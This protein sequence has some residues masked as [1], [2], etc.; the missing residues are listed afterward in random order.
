MNFFAKLLLGTKEP[1]YT[2]RRHA[3][4]IYK[5]NVIRIWRNKKYNDF[6]LERFFRL[7]L[8][9]SQFVFI[10]SLL[11]RDISGRLGLI[12][13][14]LGVE[15]YVIFKLV[16]PLSLLIFS[17][18]DSSFQ[19]AIVTYMLIETLLYL[20]CLIFLSDVFAKP[21]SYKRSILLLFLNYIEVALEYAVIYAYFNNT[22][23]EFLSTNITNMKAVYF[24]FVTSATVGYGDIYPKTDLGYF[25]VV[26]QIL[27]SLIFVALYLNFYSSRIENISYYNKK[28][29]VQF[30]E[31]NFK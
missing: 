8:A 25:I 12:G 15:F 28:E 16:L 5:L 29:K 27:V 31:R 10:L 22:K 7:F 19:I 23:R 4:F 2:I 21:I 14:K 3:I 6:G 13:R 20:N 1:K 17:R 30:R 18:I 24:S 26:S 9:C 11:V